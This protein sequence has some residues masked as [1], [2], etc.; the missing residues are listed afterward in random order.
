MTLKSIIFIQIVV[1]NYFTTAAEQNLGGGWRG[2]PAHSSITT[3]GIQ[4]SYCITFIK[5]ATEK[6]WFHIVY[7][8]C[9]FLC[10]FNVIM[11]SIIPP[12]QTTYNLYVEVEKSHW[13]RI[14]CRNVNVHTCIGYSDFIRFFYLFLTRTRKLNEWK[15]QISIFF[16]Q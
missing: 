8:R 11:W 10:S 1:K 4:K 13:Q 16:C 7:N 3:F 6:K 9:A 5:Y 12:F 14:Q 2:L 15:F